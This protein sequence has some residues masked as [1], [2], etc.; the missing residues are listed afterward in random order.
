MASELTLQ[1]SRRLC[2]RGYLLNEHHQNRHLVTRIKS[3]PG[4]FISHTPTPSRASSLTFTRLPYDIPN[5]FHR[6]R[7]LQLQEPNLSACSLLGAR[8]S[9]VCNLVLISPNVCVCLLPPRPNRILT[10]PLTQSLNPMPVNTHAHP[11]VN[12]RF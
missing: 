3:V 9:K 7:S 4:S 12:P 6:R 8:T 10:Q 11:K 1:S 2:Q 5:Q